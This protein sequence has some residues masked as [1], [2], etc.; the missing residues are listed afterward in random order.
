[1]PSP[2]AVDTSQA[3][4]VEPLLVAGRIESHPFALNGEYRIGIPV[5]GD[6]W[7]LGEIDDALAYIGVCIEDREEA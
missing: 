3:S 7:R 1:M 5:S 6:G 4:G 2:R